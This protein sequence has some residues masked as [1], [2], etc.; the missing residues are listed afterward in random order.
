MDNRVNF[1]GIGIGS[2]LVL[3]ILVLSARAGHHFAVKKPGKARKRI[4]KAQIET[5]LVN[6]EELMKA[7]GFL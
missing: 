5:R 4:I 3:I 7:R 2:V 1:S 6:L